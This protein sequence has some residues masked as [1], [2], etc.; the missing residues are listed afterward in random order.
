MTFNFKYQKYVYDENSTPDL[1]VLT[2]GDYVYFRPPPN[3]RNFPWQY[4]KVIDNLGPRSYTTKT[5]Y[6]TA[7]RNRSQI[8]LAAFPVVTGYLLAYST[9]TQN[10]Q[11]ICVNHTS[12][13]AQKSCAGFLY[14]YNEPND[15][16]W[17]FIRTSS[18]ALD[19]QNLNSV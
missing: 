12:T 6:G 13:F 19:R 16:C 5:S 18:Q 3:K 2:T 8:R 14:W 15:T 1:P 9:A 4:G 10:T 7:R 17:T 11:K